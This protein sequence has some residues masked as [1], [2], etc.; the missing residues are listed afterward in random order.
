VPLL[1]LAFTTFGVFM[2]AFEDPF[3]HLE[4]SH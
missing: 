4:S 2:W 3:K 1:G